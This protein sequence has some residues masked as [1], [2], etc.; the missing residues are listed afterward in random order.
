MTPL[1]ILLHNGFENARTWLP[2]LPELARDFRPLA[3]H[4]RG[5]DPGIPLAKPEQDWVVSLHPPVDPG[6]PRA[7]AQSIPQDTVEDGIEELAEIV[8][9]HAAPGEQVLLW[10]HC[11]GGA[12]ALGYAARN[13]SR[14]G[15]IFA[16]APGLYSDRAL[17]SK[18]TWLLC[19]FQE[20]PA[21]Y[22]DYFTAM[23]GPERASI[24]W[25]SIRSHTASYIMNP[26][27]TL[28]NEI[29]GLEVPVTL[30]QGD[31]DVYFSPEYLEPVLRALPQGRS[32]I[33]PGGLH[34]LHAQHPQRALEL[35]RMALGGVQ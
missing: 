27:Y 32:I 31:R 20:L 26:R 9:T 2:L 4:R 22:Q 14:V 29:A 28:L 6:D 8:Q 24:L 33:E 16:E 3:F 17:A 7:V 34:D 30:W 1:L 13:P 10:G 35:A 12:I 11:L 19:D 5:Y 23:H 15:G 25:H 21:A 18:A